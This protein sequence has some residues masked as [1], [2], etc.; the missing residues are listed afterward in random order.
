MWWMSDKS[1]H[2]RQVFRVAELLGFEGVGESEHVEFGFMASPEGALSTREGTAISLDAVLD[3]AKRR[4]FAVIKE[5]NPNLNNAE[6]VAEAVG[7]GAL[8]YFDLSRHRKS[9]VVFKWDEALSFEGN[10]GPYLQY[11]HARL[12]SI[13]KKLDKKWKVSKDA[14]LD[15]LEHRL[16]SSLLRFPEAIE[17]ALKDYTPNI[18]ANYLYGLAQLANEFYHSHPVIQEQDEAKRK[19]RIA[20]VSGVA[21]TLTQ[22]LNLLGISAPEK[23]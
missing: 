3:E 5:K 15:S 2:F 19:A 4:A 14:E 11:T 16:V 12:K 7:I 9:D 22:G 10:T 17:D 20:L 21:L 13:L 18:L 6:G 8:K 1:I 23:M